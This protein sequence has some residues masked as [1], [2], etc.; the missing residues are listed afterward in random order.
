MVCGNECVYDEVNSL[1]ATAVCTVPS[2]ATS[3]SILNFEITASA[4]MNLTWTGTADA[5]ELSKLNDGVDNVD[6]NDDT[7][8]GCEFRTTFTTDYVGV[9]DEVS[10]FLNELSTSNARALIA[11]ILVFQGSNDEFASETVDLWTI[12][13]SLHNGW[14]SN[15]W[16]A[17]QPS[18]NSY[19]FYGASTG[20]CRVGE[21][22]LYGAVAIDN[23]DN[24]YACTPVMTIDGVEYSLDVITYDSTFTPSLDAISPRFGTVTGGTPVTLTGSFGA[25]A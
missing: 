9:I 10:I 22:K 11:D 16:D 6:Y 13:A 7:S 21:V 4:N 12:S 5:S 1:A 2:L 20:A 15:R 25:N 23:D 24:T 18:Y 19:R 14:N 17:D 8:S 3:Q